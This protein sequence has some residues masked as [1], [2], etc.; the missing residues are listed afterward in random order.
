MKLIHKNT[1]PE[2]LATY[3]NSPGACYG[4]LINNHKDIADIIRLS[5]A[6]EQGYICCYC[7]RRINGITHTRIE[8]IF[9]KSNPSY[10]SMELDYE[11]NLLAACDGG[12]LERQANPSSPSTDLYCDENKKAEVIPINPL[13]PLC[14]DK[15]LFD[16]FG[17]IFGIGS[18]AEATIKILNLNSVFLKNRRKAAIQYYISYPVADWKAEYARLNDK[19][20]DGKFE[21]FC[22]V[23]QR[24]ID[25]NFDA[26]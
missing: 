10:S 7:G 19:D 9:P 1:E 26:S 14:E 3:R 15:F 11:N 13:N 21:E 12:K 24:Y 18:D 20:S 23:L 4:D 5:L 16:E 8:H 17:E 6:D 2:E 25:I 22:F